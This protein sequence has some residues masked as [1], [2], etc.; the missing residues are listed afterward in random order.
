[1]AERS[2]PMCNS[3]EWVDG[4]LPDHSGFVG[5]KEAI[6]A[7]GEPTPDWF[8]GNDYAN[9]IAVR[10][11]RCKSCGFLYLYTGPCT[12]MKA[13]EADGKDG[14]SGKQGK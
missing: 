5:I 4:W 8:T 10:G 12:D 11:K 3:N 7:E 13:A 14:A 9:C 6:W 1:M 2:C